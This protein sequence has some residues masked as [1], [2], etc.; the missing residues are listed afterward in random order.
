VHAGVPALPREPRHRLG[1]DG[2]RDVAVA[3]VIK[4]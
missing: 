4:Q 3:V 2:Q 1:T